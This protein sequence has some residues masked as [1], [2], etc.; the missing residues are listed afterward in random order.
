M[1]LR[2]SAVTTE[3][4]GSPLASYWPSLV[5]GLMVALY[6]AYFGWLTLRA[7]DHFVDQAYDLGIYDPAIWNTVHGRPFRSTLEEP[8]DNLLGD[9]FE[10][11]LLPSR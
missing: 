8:Y 1:A 2:T 11:I 5:L 4:G 7:Y 9:H 10:P 6:V 3:S